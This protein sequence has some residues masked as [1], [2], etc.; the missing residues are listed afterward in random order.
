MV[1]PP[2]QNNRNAG[3]IGPRVGPTGAGTMLCFPL[4]LCSCRRPPPRARARPAPAQVRAH[5]QNCVQ[6]YR[7]LRLVPMLGHAGTSEPVVWHPQYKYVPPPLWGRLCDT[8]RAQVRQ[9]LA[10]DALF[11]GDALRLEFVGDLSDWSGPAPDADAKWEGLLRGPQGGQHAVV[12]CTLQEQQRLMDA[13]AD[14]VRY[15]RRGPEEDRLGFEASPF[16]FRELPP[17]RNGLYVAGPEVEARC[18]VPSGGA[19]RSRTPTV[20]VHPWHT[21]HCSARTQSVKPLVYLVPKT[22]QYHSTLH[23]VVR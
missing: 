17:A 13:C 5:R 9:A 2:P 4:H 20:R 1:A 21:A 8:V 11:A 10:V 19:G 14:A 12:V 6:L 7:R 15:L 18:A 3:V 23:I 16:L 22:P